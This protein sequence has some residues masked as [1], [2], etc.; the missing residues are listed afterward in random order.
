MQ[1][2][3]KLNI[4]LI[5]GEHSGDILGADLIRALKQQHPNATFYGIGGERMRAGGLSC[6]I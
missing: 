3:N 4:A 6:G 2:T 5:A 1:T